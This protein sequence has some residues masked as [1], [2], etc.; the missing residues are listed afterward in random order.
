MNTSIT[1][2]NE[3]ASSLLELLETNNIVTGGKVDISGVSKITGTSC[4][5]RSIINSGKFIGISSPSF[6]INGPIVD[7]D[8]NYFTSEGLTIGS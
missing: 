8:I 5:I 1:S 3:T 4:E 2:N 6:I 7:D